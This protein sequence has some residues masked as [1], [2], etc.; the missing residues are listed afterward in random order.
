MAYEIRVVEGERPA[1]EATLNE[2]A[3][4]GWQLVSCWPEGKKVVGVESE[5]E[6]KKKH[7]CS[8]SAS[9]CILFI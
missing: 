2:S 6:R 4:E 9:S 7:V 1:I 5:E 3:N 8:S